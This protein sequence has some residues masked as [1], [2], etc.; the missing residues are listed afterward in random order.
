MAV[1]WDHRPDFIATGNRFQTPGGRTEYGKQ[2]H[3]TR[4][5]LPDVLYIIHPPKEW[6]TYRK[7]GLPQP[8]LDAQGRIIYEK[9]PADPE[10]P[11]PLLDFPHLPDQIGSQEHWWVFEA[12]RRLEPRARWRDF[13]MRIQGPEKPPANNIQMDLLRGREE[14]GLVTWFE[15]SLHKEENKARD[16]ALACLTK[17]QIRNNTSRGF[18]PG[19]INPALGEAGGRIPTTPY[20]PRIRRCKPQVKAR[21]GGNDQEESKDKSESETTLKEWDNATTMNEYAV[22]ADITSNT[23]T[24]SSHVKLVAKEALALVA[25]I[26]HGTTSQGKR[27]ARYLHDYLE[28]SQQSRPSKTARNK[29]SKLSKTSV[30][31]VANMS[32]NSAL[33]G[34]SQA[35]QLVI[36]SDEPQQSRSTAIT[37]HHPFEALNTLPAPIANM[38]HNHIMQC[39]DKASSPVTVVGH[40]TVSNSKRKAIDV[41]GDL[42]YPQQTRPSK[43]TRTSLFD[44]FNVMPSDP[45]VNMGHHLPPHEMREEASTITDLAELHQPH[46]SQG[47]R[48][49]AF[50]LTSS[51]DH[52]YAPKASEGV[53]AFNATPE[54]SPDA[55]Q[56]NQQI[57]S[58]STDLG[59][60]SHLPPSNLPTPPSS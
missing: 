20:T 25:D 34:S 51:L 21:G 29:A 56:I 43:I 60:S 31:P 15:I 17:E 45:V 13:T 41:F 11:R 16:K 23:Q 12:W 58:N 44:E 24:K 3:W 50:A 48:E 27:K 39:S 55:F 47:S 8:K 10:K 54:S 14:W 4:D 35:S 53:T 46:I 6:E 30:A 40:S 26:E 57:Y 37:R 49:D 42:K 18:T 22:Q 59:D 9:W 33:Q 7:S 52:T 38:G 1:P 32:H 2:A 28:G 5:N 19:L 36:D